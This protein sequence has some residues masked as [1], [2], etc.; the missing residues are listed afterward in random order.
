MNNERMD[1]LLAYMNGLTKLANSEVSYLCTKEIGECIGWIREE[2]T[3]EPVEPKEIVELRGYTG[4]ID[5]GRNG[6]E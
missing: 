1:Y 6:I 2:L 4:F 3:K 5:K